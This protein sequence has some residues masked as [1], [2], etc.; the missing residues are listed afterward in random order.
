M[1]GP[2]AELGSV[3]YLTRKRRSAFF[4]AKEAEHCPGAGDRKE[5]PF[6]EL[7]VA[8]EINKYEIL[9]LALVS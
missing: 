4:R 9:L 7:I 6:Q 2:K 5:K 3:W 8:M 1:P